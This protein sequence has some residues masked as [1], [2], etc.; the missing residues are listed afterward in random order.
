MIRC[1][2]KRRFDGLEQFIYLPFV[3]WSSATFCVYNA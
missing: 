2:K 3:D 1:R